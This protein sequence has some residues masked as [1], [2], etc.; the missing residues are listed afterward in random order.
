M[1]HLPIRLIVVH[2]TGSP[3]TTT[4]EMVDE[5]H[6]ARGWSGIGYHYLISAGGIVRKGRADSTVG[7]HCHGHNTGSIGVCASGS[8]A[9]GM[10]WDND[11]ERQ[12]I[13]LITDLCRAWRLMP[14]QIRG[15]CE[16]D[17]ANKPLCPGVSMDAVREQVA[18][19]LVHT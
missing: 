14:H 13:L 10:P 16:L 1:S 7:A 6:L 17:P 19:R 2:C 11:Q 15:H 12:L 18:V 5:W 3:T 8:P 9:E 4:R